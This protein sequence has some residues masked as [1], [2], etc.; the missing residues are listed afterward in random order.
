MKR[1]FAILV[2][3]L[4]VSV[5]FGKDII[6]Y[7]LM[8]SNV[9]CDSVR[10]FCGDNCSN[11]PFYPTLC[12]PTE[13]GSAWSGGGATSATKQLYCA[14]A[15][16]ANCHYSGSPKATGINSNNQAMPCKVSEDGKTANCRCKVFTGPNYVNIDGIM[17]L[18]VYYK[19][20]AVCGKDGSKC[21]NL[22]TC[23]PDGR[24]DCKGVEAPVCKYIADQNTLDD[25]VSFIPGADLISTYGFDM[26]KDYD[27]AKPGEGVK[28]QNI[29]VA[30]CMTQPCK[31]EKGSK[32]YATCSCPITNMKTMMLS[33][34]GVSCDLPK[35]YVWE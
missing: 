25:N 32:E 35:G 33:Q 3:V 27:I 16:Y 7:P 23:L 12:K 8:E 13:Y 1:L 29:D 18:G 15:T 5:S 2:F 11:M 31:Y 14:K 22:S 4:L 9:L 28:C 17:N 19:T 21:K 34:K 6:K 24:G 20:V 30:G 26:N 10:P